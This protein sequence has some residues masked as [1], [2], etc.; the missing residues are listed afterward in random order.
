MGASLSAA[1][2]VNGD[3]LADLVIGAPGADPDGNL[4]AGEAYVIFGG[5]G[6]GAAAPMLGQLDGQNGFRV[7]GGERNQGAGRSVSDGG[8]VNGDGLNDLLIGSPGSSLASLI[9]GA[10][11][12]FDRVVDLSGLAPDQG[13]A[14]FGADSTGASLAGGGDFNGDGF[15]DLAIAAPLADGGAGRD[16]GEVYLIY[17]Q[18]TFSSGSLSLDSAKEVTENP[19]DGGR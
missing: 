4:S 6:E 12:P 11:E 1:G 17:G 7:V 10:T 9:F 16:Q 3:G 5:E 2:D 15:D 8:D 18:A 19:R 13:V 14:F